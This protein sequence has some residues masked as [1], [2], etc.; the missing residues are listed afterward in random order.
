MTT[1]RH[2]STRRR[3]LAGVVA[4]AVL[5][6]LGLGTWAFLS[7]DAYVAREIE[8][9][10]HQAT[11]TRV[12]V[13]GVNVVLKKGAGTVS[14]LRV[15]NP[16]GFSPAAVLDADAITFDIDLSS[17]R[18][19]VLV[20]ES[21]EIT[22]PR[23]RFEVSRDG[24]ANLDVLQKNAAAAGSD[25]PPAPPR[26]IR[27]DR[28]VIRGGALDADTSAMK[29][30]AE[31]VALRDIVMTNVGGRDGGTAEELAAEIVTAVRKEVMRAVA[32][33]GL[34]RYVEGEGRKR[35]K[36]RLGGVFGK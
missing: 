28:L 9:A 29:G 33:E 16:S 11:G 6:A 10:G 30:R 35:L 3:I 36:D 18:E 14:S 13:G 12:S 8:R 5:A 32:K 23:L 21:V 2:P 20:V 25:A 4:L 34:Q 24:K 27:I 26:K 17:L 15:A 22:K 19:D 7:L 1:T 31:H